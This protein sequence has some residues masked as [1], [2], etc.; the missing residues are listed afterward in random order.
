MLNSFFLKIMDQEH[1][2]LLYAFVSFIATAILLKLDFSFLPRDQGRIYALNGELSKGKTR[3]VGLIMMICFVFFSILFIPF[4]LEF[5]L[6]AALI[7]IEMISGYLDDAS[8]S[9]WSDYKKGIIDLII[10]VLIALIFVFHNSSNIYIGRY[11]ITI[12]PV[13]YVILASVL[14][15]MSINAVNCTDGVDGLSST[16]GIISMVSVLLIFSS[17]ESSYAGYTLLFISVLSSY[18]LFNVSPSIMLMGDAGSRPLGVFLAILAMKTGHPFSYLLFCFVFIFDGLP[19]L[20]KVFLK[21]FLKI[22]ILKKIRTP[23]HD[24]VRKNHKWSDPQVVLRFGFIQIVFS[25][26]LYIILCF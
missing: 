25:I 17:L 11:L 20:V 21:R 13:I 9:P 23:L 1:A 10:S 19:G 6:Y 5:I 18:L 12:H 8:S 15:W 4:S 3:G 24:E 7:I 2:L 14:V 22:S 16:V 26:I